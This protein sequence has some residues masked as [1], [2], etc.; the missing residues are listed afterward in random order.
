MASF[1]G[2]DWLNRSFVRRVSYIPLEEQS[3]HTQLKKAFERGV[4]EGFGIGFRR[5]TYGGYVSGFI[6]GVS[7]MLLIFFKT[8]GSSSTSS[9]E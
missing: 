6:T 5:G 4:D 7:V 2:L 9:R 1:S 3:D 8:R